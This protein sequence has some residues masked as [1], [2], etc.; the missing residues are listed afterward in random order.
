MSQ[1]L[2]D[3]EVQ[4][5]ERRILNELPPIKAFVEQWIWYIVLSVVMIGGSLFMGAL[6]FHHFGNLSW[7]DSYLNASM[8]LTGMGPVNT[9]HTT[10]GKEFDI[11][12]ALYS[13]I[14]FLGFVGVLFYP[15]YAR[16]M[17]MLH[18]NIYQKK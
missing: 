18:I 16:L 4:Q 3:E 12:Y 13:G 8:L 17:H 2:L 11:A 9:L 14:A 1:E 10:A 15:L 7:V 6:G 5:V